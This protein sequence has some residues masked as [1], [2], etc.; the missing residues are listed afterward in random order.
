MGP[1]RNWPLAFCDFRTLAIPE[2]LEAV[3][4][5]HRDYA[6]EQFMLYH[7]PSQKWYFL[8]NQEVHDVVLIKHAD[9][10]GTSIPCKSLLL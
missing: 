8:D 4:I 6:G 10:R 5:I 7:N 9:S 2:D 3:D 1:N